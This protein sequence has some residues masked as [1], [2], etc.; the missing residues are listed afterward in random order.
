MS[1]TKL[2][3]PQ[4]EKRNYYIHEIRTRCFLKSNTQRRSTANYKTIEI[5]ML[6]K[7]LEFKVEIVQKEIKLLISEKHKKKLRKRKSA[8]KFKIQGTE[9]PE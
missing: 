6:I 3:Y 7:V 4:V 1:Q 9:V 8:R 2:Q 5:K